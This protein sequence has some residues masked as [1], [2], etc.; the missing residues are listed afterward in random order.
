MIIIMWIKIICIVFILI[1]I[2]VII[3]S[4][5]NIT[6][7]I[8]LIIYIISTFKSLWKS[9]VTNDAGLFIIGTILTYYSL[10][11]CSVKICLKQF[12]PLFNWLTLTYSA[13][14]SCSIFGCNFQAEKY[15]FE[16]LLS[17]GAEWYSSFSNLK[18]ITV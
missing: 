5:I 7:I 16:I 4:L 2:N 13:Y 3:I 8:T 10:L 11:L 1:I 15:L 12:E 17:W 6:L 14:Y 18:T 9:R